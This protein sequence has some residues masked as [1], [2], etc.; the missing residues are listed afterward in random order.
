MKFSLD[1]VLYLNLP[2]QRRSLERLFQFLH[3]LLLLSHHEIVTSSTIRSTSPN[4]AIHREWLSLITH[5]SRGIQTF[6]LLLTKRCRWLIENYHFR[7]YSY[8]LC[9]LDQLLLP[10]KVPQ[11]LL[12]LKYQR[13]CFLK[14]FC[15]HHG[16]FSVIKQTYSSAYFPKIYFHPLIDLVL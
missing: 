2:L 13:Q 8:R 7:I 4:D 14:L 16:F 10:T 3:L 6:N 12:Q 5:S 1:S 15:R 9:Y 11:Q